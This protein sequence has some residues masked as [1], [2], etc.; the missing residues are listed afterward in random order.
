MITIRSQGVRR[1]LCEKCHEKEAVVSIVEVVNGKERKLRLCR[2][3]AA[4]GAGGG[5]A[6]MQM[7]ANSVLGGLISGLFGMP[8]PDLSENEESEEDSRQTNVIC[9]SCG[10]SY[11]EFVKYGTLGCPQCYASF[12]FLLDRYMKKMQGSSRHAGREPLYNEETVHVPGTQQRTE[13]IED[14]DGDEQICVVVDLNASRNELT[15]ALSRAVA[16]E[17]YEEA[18]R[19]RDLLRKTEGA[20]QDA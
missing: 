5:I 11:D 1:M 12:G 7:S 14:A 10:M 20:V 4:E 8:Q 6:I 15:A 9:P 17:D 3:C 2:D 13:L 16:R 19:L 18:A